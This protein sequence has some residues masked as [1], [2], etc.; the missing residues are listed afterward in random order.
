[1]AGELMIERMEACGLVRLGGA[2]ELGH[3]CQGSDLHAAYIL[4]ALCVMVVLLKCS[5]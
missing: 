4:I 3:A 1:M 5:E 2:M